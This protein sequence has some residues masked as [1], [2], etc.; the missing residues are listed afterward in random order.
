MALHM[1]DKNEIKIV[2]D[3]PIKE[4]VSMKFTRKDKRF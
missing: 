1:T 2:F 4:L 3:Y